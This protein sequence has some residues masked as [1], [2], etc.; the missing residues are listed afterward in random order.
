M[1]RSQSDST[2]NRRTFIRNTS[3][4]ATTIGLSLTKEGLLE[5]AEAEKTEEKD[6]IQFRTL[7]RTGLK[8]SEI[9]FGGIQI[10]DTALLDA[11]IDRGINL[12]HTSPGYGGGK[13]IQLFGQ[14]MK[15]KRKKVVLALKASPVGGIDEHL[16]TLNTDHVDILIP[17]MH[18]VKPSRS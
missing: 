12:I 14:V 15:T 5:A 16:K 7:G 4:A 6:G 9:A 10:Q 2:W 3:L 1:P 11:A 13:S 17:P 8:V 18:S